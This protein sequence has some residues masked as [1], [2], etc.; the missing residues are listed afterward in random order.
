MAVHQNGFN[1]TLPTSEQAGMF[2]HLFWQSLRQFSLQDLRGN[3]PIG[4]AERLDNAQD[5]FWG[6]PRFLPGFL[7]TFVT[8]GDLD[9]PCDIYECLTMTQVKEIFQGQEPGL[10]IYLLPGI[11]NTHSDPDDDGIMIISLECN[12]GFYSDEADVEKFAF[13]H[14]EVKTRQLN[15]SELHISLESAEFA[16]L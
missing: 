8:A 4:P 15:D 6:V 7:L 13:V 5:V 2:A 9:H 10:H 3:A 11:V 12:L 14:F 16:W 1:Q